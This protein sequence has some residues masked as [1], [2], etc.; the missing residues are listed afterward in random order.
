MSKA[1]DKALYTLSRMPFLCSN[2]TESLMISTKCIII[3]PFYVSANKKAPSE[4]LEAS[5]QNGAGNENRT[6][7]TQLGKLMFYR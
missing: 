5:R 7:D 6:R 2:E 1:G 4:R 3:R